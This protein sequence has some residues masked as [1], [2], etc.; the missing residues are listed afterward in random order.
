[1][2]I[3]IDQ[4]GYQLRNLGD[5]AMLQVTVTRL[6]SLWPNASIQVI[7]T[8]PERLNLCCP[9][10]QHLL[11]Y[12]REVWF[13]PLIR[14]AYKRL[15]N[16]FVSNLEWQF[17]NYSPAFARYLIDFK[18]RKTPDKAK[19]FKIFMQS[20]Y[21]ADLV[22][23]SGGGYITDAFEKH[24]ISVLETLRLAAEFG[25]PTAML[26]QGLG[27]ITKKELLNKAKAVLPL[28]NLIGLREQ[29][30]GISLLNSI[31]VSQNRI[32]ITGDDAIELAYKAR[33]EE[34]GKGIGVNLRYAKYSSVSQEVFE[35][36]R[37]A[38]QDVAKNKNAPLVPVPISYYRYEYEGGYEEPD[39]V[40]IQKLL[41]GYDDNSDGGQSLDTVLKV[42]QQVGD[43]RVVVTGSYHAGVFALSQGIPVVG[44]AKSEYYVNKFLGLADQFGVG[45]EVVLLNTE[46][47]REKL[48]NT[49][50][51]AYD[52]SEKLR[53]QLLAAAQKQVEIGQIAY[54]R[55]YEIVSSR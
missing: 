44:L 24:S 13:S 4:S 27:P 45:C 18:L 48:V 43:C 23:A 21:D 3:L 41:Q 14:S 7:T 50:T 34:L 33:R 6:T 29:K 11:P 2:K 9:K 54:K 47:L 37:L 38:L 22:V 28:V 30:A 26:G 55:I 19:E 53:P 31:G 49:I 32:I 39:S 20:V 17:R 51:T 15:P 10:V 25:K 52:S 35:T 36:I 42:I 16:Q 5:I 8:D 12:G 40:S 1:M 46:H